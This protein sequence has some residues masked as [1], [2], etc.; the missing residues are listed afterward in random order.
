VFGCSAAASKTFYYK[1]TPPLVL[2]PTAALLDKQL[3]LMHKASQ[4]C[5]SSSVDCFY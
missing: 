5:I 2:P 4:W 1:W 3:H